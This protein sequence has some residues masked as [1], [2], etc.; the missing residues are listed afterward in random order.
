MIDMML[1]CAASSNV[2]QHINWNEYYTGHIPNNANGM[3]E[4]DQMRIV[5]ENDQQTLESIRNIG[6]QN[7]L[8]ATIWTY[9]VGANEYERSITYDSEGIKILETDSVNNRAAVAPGSLDGYFP[10]GFATAGSNPTPDQ[11]ESTLAQLRKDK[12]G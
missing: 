6:N 10:E 12:C 7:D 3:P 11:L 5:S 9:V 2:V 1:N 8:H 4:T